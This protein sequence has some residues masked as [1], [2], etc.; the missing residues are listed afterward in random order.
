[1][2]RVLKLNMLKNPLKL[3]YSLGLG[4]TSQ[5]TLIS[6]NIFERKLFTTPLCEGKVKK[7]RREKEN[8]AIKEIISNLQENEDEERVEFDDGLPKDYKDLSV[9]IG[10]RRIDTLIHRGKVKVNDE[11]LKKKSYN[12]EKGD[13][14]DVFLQTYPENSELAQISR[15]C[16]K[17]Y[18]LEENGYCIEVKLWRNMLVE[19]WKKEF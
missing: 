16:V 3:A 8:Q 15:I 4:Q 19:K 9:H 2:N 7:L 1:M 14:I 10:S 12:V 11:F 17:D 6:D 13:V 18:L 5:K